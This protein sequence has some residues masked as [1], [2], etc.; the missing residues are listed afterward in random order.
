M[1]EFMGQT[2]MELPVRGARCAVAGGRCDYRAQAQRS[3]TATPSSAVSMCSPQPSQVGFEQ[4]WQ[5]TRAH[6]GVPLV[7]G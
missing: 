2:D 4:F 7:V 3:A 6:M 1:A 5:V